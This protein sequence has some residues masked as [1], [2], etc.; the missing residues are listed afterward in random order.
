M[1]QPISDDNISLN[2]IIIN[3]NLNLKLNYPHTVLFEETIKWK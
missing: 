3:L 2:C 1:T